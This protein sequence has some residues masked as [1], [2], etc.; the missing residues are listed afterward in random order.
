M[1][2]QVMSWAIETDCPNPSAKLVLI[3]LSNYAD[4]DGNAHPGQKRLAKDTGLSVAT[5]KRALNSLEGVGLIARCHRQRA[6]GSRTSDQYFVGKSKGSNCAVGTQSKGSNCTN[7]RAHHE[8]PHIGKPIFEPSVEPSDARA[9]KFDQFWDVY[10]NKVGKRI[11]S[12]SFGQALKRTSFEKLMNGLDRYINKTDDRPWCNP[13]TW[14]NQDRWEDQPSTPNQ[15]QTTAGFLN[16]MANRM[17]TYG[18]E[19]NIET[20]GNDVGRLPRPHPVAG[21]NS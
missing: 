4:K 11:A 21:R 3:C 6:D 5:I 10:P 1:S 17:E 7:P 19:G 15:K 2:V 14:L 12:K 9:S 18:H 20:I 16:E 13:S 8:L